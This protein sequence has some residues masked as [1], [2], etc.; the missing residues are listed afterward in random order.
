MQSTNIAR[1]RKTAG[2]NSDKHVM[3]Q[4]NGKEEKRHVH[5][6]VSRRKMKRDTKLTRG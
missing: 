1:F 4:G 3:A 6:S 2:Q 5:W